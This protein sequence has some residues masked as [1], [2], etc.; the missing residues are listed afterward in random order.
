M[1]LRWPDRSFF[2]PAIMPLIHASQRKFG[3]ASQ[4]DMIRAA[5][6]VYA[7]G[8]WLW[9]V[10]RW[11]RALEFAMMAEDLDP[12]HFPHWAEVPDEGTV[13]CPVCGGQTQPPL[14]G[15]HAVPVSDR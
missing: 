8:G 13:R 2:A 9:S 1:R 11:S 6:A 5:K 10:F 3:F 4:Q 15:W 12:V 14:D 7:V